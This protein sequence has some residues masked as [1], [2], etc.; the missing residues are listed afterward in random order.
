MKDMYKNTANSHTG[1]G[2]VNTTIQIHTVTLSASNNKQHYI[3]INNPQVSP[4]VCPAEDQL[5]CLPLELHKQSLRSL[6][7]PIG[8]KQQCLCPVSGLLG[9]PV[10]L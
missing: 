10:F 2:Q 4:T 1:C 7:K 8:I 6:S 5:H 3:H 9:S